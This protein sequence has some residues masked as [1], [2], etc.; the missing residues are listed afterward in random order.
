MNVLIDIYLGDIHA[1][2]ATNNLIAAAIDTRMYHEYTQSNGALFN[3][4]CPL[5]QEVI[6]LIYKYYYYYNYIDYNVN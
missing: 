6:F 4:L 2:T 5:N 1:V 3:R